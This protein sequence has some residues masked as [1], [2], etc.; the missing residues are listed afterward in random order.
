MLFAANYVLV[1]MI[2]LSTKM[3]TD[4]PI[5]GLCIDSIMHQHH[6]THADVMPYQ[7]AKALAMSI[8]I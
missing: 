3:D 7:H 6:L 2:L 1:V 8:L 4:S 5:S